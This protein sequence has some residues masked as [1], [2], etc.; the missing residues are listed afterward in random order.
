MTAAPLPDPFS[1]YNGERLTDSTDWP[2]RRKELLESV[3]EIEYGSLPPPAGVRGELLNTIAVRDTGIEHRQ[4]RLVAEIEPPISFVLDLLIPRSNDPLP[5]ILNGDRCWRHLTDEIAQLVTSR[6]YILATF[7]RTEIAPDHNKYG[8]TVGL[9]ASFPDM[10][11]GALS[12]WAWGYHRAVDYLLTMS[13]VDE[14]KIAISGHSRGG[15]AVL[16]AGAT[17]E[18]IALTNPNDSGC[19]GAGCFRI[20]GEGSETMADIISRYHYWFSPKLEAYIGREEELPFDQHFLKAAAAP[21]LLLT[22]EALDDLWSNPSGTWH[23]HAAAKEIYRF[24]DVEDRI[25]IWY[26][27][28]GHAHGIPD[29]EALLDFADWHFCGKTP[30][31]RFNHNPFEGK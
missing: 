27:P 12:A 29:F 2:R 10:D 11:F 16:L 13:E 19:G 26:R 9:Y 28:G 24:L 15:K 6:G 30:L 22:T 18:R 14:V 17:D 31:K 4:V 20:E 25:G 1:F 7:N 21:R 8:R 3:L 23:T 5:V